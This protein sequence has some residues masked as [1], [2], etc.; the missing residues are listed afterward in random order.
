MDAASHPV[1]V[2]FRRSSPAGLVALMALSA[3]SSWCVSPALPCSTQKNGDLLSVLT[4]LISLPFRN[5][6]DLHTV[7]AGAWGR[8][9]T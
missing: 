1:G 2:T 8:G 6:I 3:I 5:T 7:I 4:R 9:A